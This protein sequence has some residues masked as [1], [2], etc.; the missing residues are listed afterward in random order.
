VGA[1]FDAVTITVDRP[2]ASTGVKKAYTPAGK[3]LWVNLT[4]DAVEPAAREIADDP[5][6]PCLMVKLSGTAVSPESESAFE[7]SKRRTWL[8]SRRG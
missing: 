4:G 2:V 8:P 6:A 7:A 1:V 5:P 3:P